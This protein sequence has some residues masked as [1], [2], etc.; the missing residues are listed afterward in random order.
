MKKILI[1][2]MLCSSAV[3]EDFVTA[4]RIFGQMVISGMTDTNLIVVSGAGVTTANGTYTN[5]LG[6]YIKGENDISYVAG[7]WAMYDEDAGAIVYTNSSA[8]PTNTWY[9]TGG[10]YDPAPS[11][12]YGTMTITNSL[13]Y[14][15]PSAAMPVSTWTNSVMWLTAESPV[16]NAG[17]TNA[18]WIC[19]AKNCAGNAAQTI[20]ASQ[21]TRTL[22]G[23]IWSLNFDGSDDQIIVPQGTPINLTSNLTM[24]AWLKPST[25]GEAGYVFSKGIANSDRRYNLYI[26]GSSIV[27]NESATQISKN[28]SIST[29]WNHV[30]ISLTVTNLEFYANG[31]SVG[32]ATLT[33][34]ALPANTD[35][36]YIGNRMGGATSA[37]YFGGAIRQ[38][39]L[40]NRVLTAQEILEMYNRGIRE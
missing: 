33:G 39:R 17:T 10:A 15:V 34:G 20:E 29:N 6:H 25:V 21:P 19:Y 5:S 16:Y 11:V 27:F 31:A 28:A 8:S 9:S 36:L 30:A 1:A 3:A 26:N 37:T 22:T 14:S 40:F 23:N 24:A 18:Q 12:A 13:G 32:S 38:A 2:L 4:N 35:N 7:G